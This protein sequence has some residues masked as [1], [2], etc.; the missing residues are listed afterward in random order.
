MAKV[1]S[2]PLPNPTSGNDYD[3]IQFDEFIRLN[4][5]IECECPVVRYYQNLEDD[6]CDYMDSA[7]IN[8]GLTYSKF[9]EEYKKFSEDACVYDP[10]IIE[11]KTYAYSSYELD[12]LFKSEF[13]YR[14]TNDSVV[15]KGISNEKPFYQYLKLEECKKGDDICFPGFISTSVCKEKAQNFSCGVSKIILVINR[16]DLVNAIVPKNSKIRNTPSS[17]IPEQEIILNRN[18]RMTV[19]KTYSCSGYQYI[20]LEVTN[21]TP[22]A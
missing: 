16:L 9:G 22:I 18:T 11:L 5:I 21:R 19:T 1:I 17:N 20:H 6:S 10:D 2:K 15:F 13:A 4:S 7:E 8:H 3:W 12:N 14:F